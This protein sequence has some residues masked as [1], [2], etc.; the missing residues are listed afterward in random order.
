[1]YAGTESL[2]LGYP[3][4]QSIELEALVGIECRAY[5]IIV[6]ARN[7]ADLFCCAAAKGGQMQCIRTPVLGILTAFDQISLLKFVQQRD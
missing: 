4:Q 3:A 5:G 2:L 1:M 7:T 6:F